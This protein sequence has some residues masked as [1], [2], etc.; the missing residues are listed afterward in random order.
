M[1]GYNLSALCGT[2]TLEI[3]NIHSHSLGLCF[4]KLFIITPV[5]ALLAIISAYFIGR[6]SDYIIR[7]KNELAILYCRIAVVAAMII[8]S[9]IIEP[10]LLLLEANVKIFWAD[11]VSFGVQ[12]NIS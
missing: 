9:V 2:P 6:Q 10:V 1:D 11:I 4:Q 8:F 7:S 12:V 3:W 5:F